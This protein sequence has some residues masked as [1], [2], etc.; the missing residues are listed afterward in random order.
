MDAPV[1]RSS[2]RGGAW[3]WA[4]VTAAVRTAGRRLRLAGERAVVAGPARG[5]SDVERGPRSHALEPGRKRDGNAPAEERTALGKRVVKELLCGEVAECLEKDG[6]KRGRR[7]EVWVPR[8][9]K[10]RAR[11]VQASEVSV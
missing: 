9:Q 3:A 8:A 10:G 4:V 5:P 6:T 11:R 2:F 7:L 1:R